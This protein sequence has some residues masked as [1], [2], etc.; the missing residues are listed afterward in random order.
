[1]AGSAGAC[2]LAANTSEAERLKALAFEGLALR[3][4]SAR[5]KNI[6]RIN[7][8]RSTDHDF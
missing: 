8:A 2:P 4:H 5:P 3:I 6:A 7:S 1:M